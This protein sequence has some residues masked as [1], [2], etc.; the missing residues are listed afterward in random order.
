MDITILTNQ[1]VIMKAL[2]TLIT[3]LNMVMA[4]KEQIIFTE[5]RIAGFKIT[6]SQNR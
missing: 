5:A 2:L 3:D 1:V 4:L 6:I